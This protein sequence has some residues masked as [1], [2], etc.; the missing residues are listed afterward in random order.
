MRALRA[1]WE[2]FKAVG[3]G[4]R[5][6][7]QTDQIFRYFVLTTLRKIGLF[8]YLREP[9]SY[10]EILAH[11]EFEETEYVQDTL[12]ILLHDKGKPILQN[13]EEYVVNPDFEF[14]EISS[15]LGRT[16]PRI[17]PMSLMAEAM[18][19]NIVDRMRAE[20]Q[21]LRQVFEKDE[22]TVVKMFNE[23]LSKGPYTAIRR[24]CFAFLG[25][26]D[27]NWLRGKHLLD[28]GCAK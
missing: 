4:M 28:V 24:G 9:R 22:Y 6:G 19:T 7:R 3:G 2:I 23:L 12:S 15:I 13:S 25:R 5:A 20:R 21:G 14:P 1:W 10:G 18:H 8:E 16:D 26:A 11:F 17:R 27:R